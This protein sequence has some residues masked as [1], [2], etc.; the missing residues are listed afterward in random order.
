MRNTPCIT[1][2]EQKP[3]AIIGM[4]QVGKTTLLNALAEELQRPFVKTDERFIQRHG[5]MRRFRHTLLNFQRAEEKLI[6][7]ALRPGRIVEIGS[8]A[9]EW[10]PSRQL[11]HDRAF[12]VWIHAE[13][14][15]IYE[16]MMYEDSVIDTH[17]EL[18]RAIVEAVLQRNPLYEKVAN[19]IVSA[20]ESTAEQV[21]QILRSMHGDGDLAKSA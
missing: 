6:R 8:G 13:I 17:C 15:L 21:R 20:H 7:Q 1:G 10:E 18:Y 4:R 3:I 16:R 12:N 19:I 2:A 14:P 11:L 9:V 5:D